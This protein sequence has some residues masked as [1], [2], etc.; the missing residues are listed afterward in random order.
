[1]ETDIKIQDY[2]KQCN[3][4][5][6]K[7]CDK[8]VKIFKIILQKVANI[9]LSWMKNLQPGLDE[10]DRDQTGIQVLDII[11]RHGPESQYVNV[12]N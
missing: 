12:S 7:Q 3:K 10:V 1:M 4:Q 2:K 9:D 6:D 8:H 5:C 11:M